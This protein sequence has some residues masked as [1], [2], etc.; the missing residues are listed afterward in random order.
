V[1]D[2]EDIDPA[3]EAPHRDHEVTVIL[4]YQSDATVEVYVGIWNAIFA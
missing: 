4:A 3:I 1:G 2:W